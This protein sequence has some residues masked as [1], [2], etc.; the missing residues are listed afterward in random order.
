MIQ[1]LA[2]LGLVATLF[3]VLAVTSPY[4]LT[5]ANLSS[6]VR[7]TAVINTMALGPRLP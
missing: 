7:Q 6:V 3:V 2:L 1:R 5:A 4:F